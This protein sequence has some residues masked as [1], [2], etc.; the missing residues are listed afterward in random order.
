MILKGRV[1][2]KVGWRDEGRV[3]EERR[4]KRVGFG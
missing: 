1:E 2:L 3:G 4:I